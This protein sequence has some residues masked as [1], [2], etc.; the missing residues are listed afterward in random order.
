MT[1]GTLGYKIRSDISEL[2]IVHIRETDGNPVSIRLDAFPVSVLAGRVLSVEPQK[3][4]KEG[5]TYYRTNIALPKNKLGIRPGMSADLS[6]LVT[7]KEAVLKVPEL[8]I[9]SDANGKYVTLLQ[10]NKQVKTPVTTGISDGE[11]IEI[12]SG[13]AEGQTIVISAD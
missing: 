12:L 11:Y 2:D 3:I 6:I 13:L 10:K 7:Q 1:L 9:T 5:D 8:A 4:D